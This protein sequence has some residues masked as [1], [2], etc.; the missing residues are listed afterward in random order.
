[1]GFLG[2]PTANLNYLTQAPGIFLSF[3]KNRESVLFSVSPSRKNAKESS[4][5]LG[6]SNEKTG[7][8]F[9]ANNKVAESSPLDM[10]FVYVAQK[11]KVKSGL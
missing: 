2:V 6:S 4:F 9:W 3:L 10:I 7:A 11:I 8:T 5:F 1:M